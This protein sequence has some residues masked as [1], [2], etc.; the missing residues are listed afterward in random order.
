M[1]FCALMIDTL[2]PAKAML[3]D[4]AYDAAWFRAAL[5]KPGRVA[6]TSAPRWI[7]PSTA[8]SD[9]A[10]PAHNSSQARDDL[11][12][13]YSTFA[14]V[15]RH[16]RAARKGKYR[17]RDLT[18]SYINAVLAGQPYAQLAGYGAGASCHK[19]SCTFTAA[20]Q[21]KA[22]PQDCPYWLWSNCV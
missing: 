18:L 10:D 8:Y 14:I 12:Y 5:A 4:R 6:Y 19:A 7:S 11:C 9:R 21:K 15:E 1:G 3:G 2:P 22:T 17:S 16:E 20:K 13:I